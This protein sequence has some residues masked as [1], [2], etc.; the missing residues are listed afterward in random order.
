L[1]LRFSGNTTVHLYSL[2]I[3]YQYPVMKLQ[4]DISVN[5]INILWYDKDTIGILTQLSWRL[6]YSIHSYKYNVSHSTRNQRNIYQ[7][8]DQVIIIDIK[9]LNSIKCEIMWDLTMTFIMYEQNVPFF[10]EI[11]KNTISGHYFVIN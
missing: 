5:G 11:L 1:L 8:I 4:Y 3:S 10:M 9:K 2:V 7:C 6:R